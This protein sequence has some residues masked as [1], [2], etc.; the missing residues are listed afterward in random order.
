MLAEMPSH[1]LFDWQK[2]LKYGTS[3]ERLIDK[4][5]SMIAAILA[6]GLFKGSRK[7]K[8]KDFTLFLDKPVYR[9]PTYMRNKMIAMTLLAGGTI[10]DKRKK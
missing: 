7:F 6:N 1:V 8:P 3:A 4:H 9:S 5:L 2:Y 10:I